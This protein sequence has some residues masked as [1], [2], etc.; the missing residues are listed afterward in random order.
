MWTVWRHDVDGR[1]GQG[2]RVSLPRR[3]YL[4]DLTDAQWALIEHPQDRA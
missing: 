2:V 4:S 1:D 3:G